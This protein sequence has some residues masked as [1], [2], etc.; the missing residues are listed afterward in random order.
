MTLCNIVTSLRQFPEEMRLFA[1]KEDPFIRI[2]LPSEL[3]LEVALCAIEDGHSIE[4]EII[5][6]LAHSLV[7]RKDCLQ[8]KQIKIEENF[9]NYSIKKQ[10]KKHIKGEK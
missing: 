3:M 10:T 5:S 4:S 1:E 2:Q 7:K 8:L 6:R 9:K